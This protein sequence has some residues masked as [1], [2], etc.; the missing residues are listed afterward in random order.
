MKT[1]LLAVGVIALAFMSLSTPVLA[2]SGWTAQ[3][4]YD[5]SCTGTTAGSND[6]Y[7]WTADITD[8][9][10]RAMTN[11]YF[12]ITGFGCSRGKITVTLTWDSSLGTPPETIVIKEHATAKWEATDVNH[13]ALGA[14]TTRKGW[15]TTSLGGTYNEDFDVYAGPCPFKGV[16][17]SVRYVKV[18]SSS[19]QI[20]RIASLFAA[21]QSKA[22]SQFHAEYLEESCSFE[23]HLTDGMDVIPFDEVTVVAPPGRGASPN[24]H[25][26]GDDP[27]DLATGAQSSL[28]APDIV[29]YNP[30]GPSATYMRNYY[31]ERAKSNHASQGLSA[32]W[33]DN[34][35]VSAIA[36]APGT[37][38]ALKLLYPNGA[39]ELLTPV[40]PVSSGVQATFTAPAGAPYFVTGMPSAT[41]GQWQ[42]IKITFSDQSKW[43][44]T[45]AGSGAY[46]LSKID[47][48]MDRYVSILRDPSKGWRIRSVSDDSNP[49]HCLLT[50]NYSGN[51]LASVA[52]AYGRKVTFTFGAAAG[53]TC[54][55]SFSG[56]VPSQT[57][58]PAA[59][60]T[61]GY[62]AIGTPARA[63][64]TSTTDPSPT[65]AGT[66]TDTI[67]YYTDA[68]DNFSYGK[69]RSLVDAHGN[70][71]EYTYESDCYTRVKVK[72]LA[73]TVEA[74]WMANFD[75]DNG[76]RSTG[77]TDTSN[78]YTSVAYTDPNNPSKPTIAIDKAGKQT[79]VSYDQFGNVTKS[80]DARGTVT[81][82]NYV[83]TAFPLGRLMSVQHGGKPATT[84]TYF[85][86][87]GLV[88][89]VTTPKPGATDNSMVTTFF[90]YDALGNVETVKKPGNNATG[91]ITTVYG[92]GTQPK[93][94]Q[95][96]TV[97]DVIDPDNTSDPGWS[98][99]THLSYDARGNMVSATDAQGNHVDYTYNIANQPL[100]AILP[101]IP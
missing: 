29:S 33:V 32:G 19:G 42:S 41:T 43:T 84:F 39:E 68:S 6:S 101:A 76:G 36:T 65:G 67:S 99:M 27:I 82:Y 75:P 96:L 91:T 45:P 74:E 25:P 78:R 4:S 3:Y 92:Y 9:T 37:W 77:T 22:Y 35:D 62:T 66:K 8:R 12:D 56:I 18:D 64:L 89:S 17:D 72:N 94:G 54:L 80:T 21:A 86:P 81:I 47:N 100:L 59:R 97:A 90:T 34:Y 51:Y 38:G 44:L 13:F 40:T 14:S 28:L 85:E 15:A 16:N 61:Y 53:T 30:Y 31:S 69:V 73:G 60:T 79:I 26:Y 63:L 70:A 71:H 58:S 20:V 98:R 1:R 46:R 88:E 24:D 57:A 87:S 50:F 23:V 10:V 52:D 7:I 95:P 55:L 2:T 93:L 11:G 5:G 83:Y 49:A 48:R